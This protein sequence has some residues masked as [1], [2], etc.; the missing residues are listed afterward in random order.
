[1][2]WRRNKSASEVLHSEAQARRVRRLLPARLPSGFR[3]A[4]GKVGELVEGFFVAKGSLVAVVLLAL[5]TGHADAQAIRRDGGSY[6]SSRNGQTKPQADEPP[7]ISAATENDIRRIASAL[8]TANQKQPTAEEQDQARRNLAAQE[9]IADWAPAVFWVALVELLVTAAG[10]FLI[11]R[12]LEASWTSAREAKRTADEAKRQAD[13]AEGAFTK[14]ERPHLFVESPRLEANTEVR[15]N[16]KIPT[17]WIGGPPMFQ[18]EYDIFN[19]GRS[20]AIIKERCATIFICK[21]L[22]PN[23]IEHPYDVYTDLVAIKADGSRKGWR[24]FWR[25][26]L[27]DEVIN[28][29]YLTRSGPTDQGL[30]AYLFVRL[31]Y[32]SVSGTTDEI[33]AIW[34]YLIDI[35]KFDPV[36]I[37]NFSYRR[38]GI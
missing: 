17:V 32:V 8:E 6:S 2:A 22:P 1:M 9:K 27:T 19:Y 21:E 18:A 15:L 26:D 25:G 30:R 37:E 33:G 28:G 3:I 10:V 4:G 14:L 29:L 24:V 23:P 12:T 38:L 11:W 36:V 13:A 35:E 5:T 31:R 16:P 7:S 20:P 34:E